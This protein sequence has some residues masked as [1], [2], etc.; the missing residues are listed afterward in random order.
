MRRREGSFRE[1]SPSCAMLLNVLAF[2]MF[3]AGGL[4][5]VL[6]V[7]NGFRTGRIR[8]SDSRS[9]YSL[10]RQPVRF[11]LVAL[12]FSGLAGVFLYGAVRAATEI[13]KGSP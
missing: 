7:F 8:H 4:V 13:W 5:M 10:R 2:A 9:S 6:L 1:D 12:I 3:T 11:A